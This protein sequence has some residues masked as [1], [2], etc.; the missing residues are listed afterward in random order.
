MTDS[1]TTEAT[2][3]LTARLG[4]TFALL[5]FSLVLL[6][7]RSIVSYVKGVRKTNGKRRRRLVESLGL[8]AEQRLGQAKAS[9]SSGASPSYQVIGFFHPYCNAGG[10]GERVLFEAIRYHFSRD[11]RTICVVYTGDATHSQSLTGQIRSKRRSNALPSE[12]SSIADGGGTATKEEIL[13]KVHDR[14]D[15]PLKDARYA[16]RIAFLPLQSR[17]LVSDGY[18]KRLTMLGQSFGGA[19]LAKEA[20]EELIP[21][22]FIDT[23]GYAFAFPV[24][25][26]FTQ[27]RRSTRIAA[28]VHYPTISNDMLRRVASRQA[29]H[30]NDSKVAGSWWQSRVKLVY[31]RLFAR[32]YAW[33][34]R[35]ADVLVAN[36]TWTANHINSLLG[37]D[38]AARIVYPPCD[39]SALSAV[40]QSAPSERQ[41]TLVSLAQFRPEKEH[42]TQIRILAKIFENRP[43]LKRNDDAGVKLIMMGSCRNEGDEARID[44]LR[45]LAKGLDV[46]AQTHFVINAPYSDILANLSTASIGLS[47]MVDEHFGINVVEFMAAGLITLSHASAGPLMDI[48][49]PDEN[50]DPT[51]YHAHDVDE[52]ARRAIEILGL[53][54]QEQSAIRQRATKRATEVFS[55]E[56]FCKAWQEGLARCWS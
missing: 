16:S 28:Y 44:G 34:L 36:G 55:R 23:M 45:A 3:S 22:V 9:S 6:I 2:A 51:G 48:A 56:A 29:G 25:R 7:F 8:P 38:S 54:V 11:D 12:S 27:A 52:F 41:R 40:A 4:V 53:S 21:D 50:G 42:A 20:C 5:S 39:V 35:R 46:E 31:Y 49:V 1:S 33:A 30:T 13:Q 26:L 15:I 17:G 19:V 43:D 14:F 32:L 47:T 10:G 18:W 24:V 37:R